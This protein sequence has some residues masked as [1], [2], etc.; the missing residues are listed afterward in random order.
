M[1]RR[2]KQTSTKKSG[3]Y[4]ETWSILE[5][6]DQRFDQTTWVRK[7]QE[8]LNH[9]NNAEIVAAIMDY[10]NERL[11]NEIYKDLDKQINPVI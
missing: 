6:W 10:C 7:V 4:R 1:R 11:R 3:T 9:T 2:V 5:H 8:K